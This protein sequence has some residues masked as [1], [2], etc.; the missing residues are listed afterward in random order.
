MPSDCIFCQVI[1]KKIQAKFEYEGD[2]MVAIQD[3]NP[4]APTHLL[5]LPRK[6]I[7]GIG[8][9]EEADRILASDMIFCAQKLAKEKKIENGYRLVFNNGSSAG[10]SVFHIHLH[11]LGGRKMAWPPG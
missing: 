1:A 10:Q 8:Q 11:L 9:L 7:S 5:V 6:H 3:I 4:Q 2:S